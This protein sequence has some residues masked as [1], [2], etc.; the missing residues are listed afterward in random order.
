MEGLMQIRVRFLGGPMHGHLGLT[1]TLDKC[2]VFFDERQKQVLLYVREN[3]V[4]DYLFSPLLSKGLTEKYD[5]AFAK[6]GTNNPS[7]TMVPQHEDGTPAA[8]FSE[9]PIT[10]EPTV[11]GYREPGDGETF[12]PPAQDFDPH[13]QSQS[14]EDVD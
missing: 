14:S 3:T 9:T 8:E 13:S 5:E 4:V 10:E 12:L 1:E 11:E 6:W 7:I 2:K